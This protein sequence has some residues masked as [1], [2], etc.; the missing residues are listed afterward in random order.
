MIELYKMAIR[1]YPKSEYTDSKRLKA[2]RL[3]W[4]R[5]V[6]MLGNKWRGRTDCTHKIN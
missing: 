3:G 4:I 2:L 6:S 5:S 1:N